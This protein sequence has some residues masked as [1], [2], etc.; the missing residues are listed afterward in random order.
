MIPKASIT[1]WRG[2]AP[3]ITDEQVEQDLILS[4]VLVNLFSD[5]L[6]NKELA[7]RGRCNILIRAR[8]CSECI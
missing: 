2:K 8:N 1:Q 7:F 5:P 3:W 4:R 6:L